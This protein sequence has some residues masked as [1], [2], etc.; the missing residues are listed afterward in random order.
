MSHIAHAVY[1]QLTFGHKTNLG[2]YIHYYMQ[3]Q[4]W[5]YLPNTDLYCIF[6][7]QSQQNPFI[8]NLAVTE[9]LTSKTAYHTSMG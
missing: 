4:L 8:K 7:K 6:K 1:E 2:V 3:N 9:Y 5:D